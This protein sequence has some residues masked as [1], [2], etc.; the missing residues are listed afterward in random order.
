MAND[1]RKK[2]LIVE[3]DSFLRELCVAKFGNT[4]H[5]VDYEEDGAVGLQKI[6]DNDYDVV[7]LDVMLP[8]KTGFE[9][10]EAL[11]E[12]GRIKQVKIVML[13]NLSDRSDV[14]KAMTLG[15]RD[16]II[17]AH[18]SPSEIV[19]KAEEWLNK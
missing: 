8:N 17:K 16:Y 10:L 6:Q 9:I 11:N 19:A 4:G 18:F 15:A 2:I 5:N 12:T 14:E 13:T 7:L 1:T 3:D